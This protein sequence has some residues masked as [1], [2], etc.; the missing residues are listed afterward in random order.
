MKLKK[1][2]IEGTTLF[3]KRDGESYRVVHPIKNEDGSINWF[4][5][6]V[7]GSWKNLIITLIVMII[8]IGFLYEYSL[9]IQTLLNCFKDM[10]SL[11]VCKQ[12]FGGENLRIIIP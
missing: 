10:S 3:L 6:L 5:L 11:E 4:N 12:S 8:V 1:I 7:G 2:Q 9:N